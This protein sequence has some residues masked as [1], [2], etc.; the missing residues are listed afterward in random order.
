MSLSVKLSKKAIIS[1][2][3]ACSPLLAAF[4]NIDFDNKPGR[5][6]KEGIV[7][8]LEYAGL[9]NPAYTISMAD[10]LAGTGMTGMKHYAEAVAWGKMQKGPNKPID[11]SKLDLF[12]ST[13]QSKGF[14]EL[15]VA[16]KS[17]NSWASKDANV[18]GGAKNPTPKKQYVHLYKRWIRDIVERYDKDGVKDMPGL[19]WPVRYYEIGSEF[20]SY[21][22]EPVE[23]YIEMLEVAYHAAHNAYNQVKIG[24]AAF[25][26]TPM[27]FSANNLKDRG[28]N[29]YQKIWQSTYIRDRHHD[30]N[31]I[32]EVL[33]RPDIFDVLNL[34]NL[35]DPYEIEHLMQWLKKEMKWRGYQK[36]VIISDTIPTSYIAWGSATRCKA[37]NKKQL[38]VLIPPAKEKDRCML[39]EFFNK[40]VKKDQQTLTWTQN[41]VA[42]DHVQRSLIAAEQGVD[43]INLSFTIDLPFLTNK[44]SQAGAGISAWAGALK[45]NPWG[46][47]QE[48]R[49][50]YYSIQQLME[51]LNGYHDIQRIRLS[52]NAARVYKVKNGKNIFY[53]AWRDPQGVILPSHNDEKIEAVFTINS[54]AALIEPLQ[55]SE[56]RSKTKKVNARNKR[57]AVTLSH[58]PIYIFPQE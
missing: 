49:P 32:K 57:V 13:Y 3:V 16:L 47:V 37:N 41:F 4:D 22:P 48:K 54:N 15:T 20:S 17:H 21:E 51:H 46:K 23:E 44:F 24:H 52:D 8:G 38:G 30:L 11:F 12:V 58:A 19:R 50:L 14:T 53:V 45:M 18:L 25:L 35:G 1:L 7:I 33:K 43:L 34:H 36:P 31:D 56:K 29:A 28:S 6:E 5:F 42:A 27:D 40:L 9:D 55:I 39:S 26:V 10:A 2:L